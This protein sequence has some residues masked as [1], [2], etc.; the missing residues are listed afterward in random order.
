MD[1]VL[2][3]DYAAAQP[4]LE[5]FMQE[6]ST[7]VLN[8]VGSRKRPDPPRSL[9]AQPGSLEVLLTWNGPQ[10]ASDITGWRIYKNNENTLIDTITDP[11]THQYKAK[12]PANTN[13]GFYVS[14][15]NALG[16]ESI[17][18]FVVGAANTDQYVTTGTSGGTT[19]STAGVP[20]GYPSEPSGGRVGGNRSLRF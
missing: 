6:Q 1:S 12:V 18:V 13:T 7:L 15:V 2:P 11:S 3:T 14:S 9:I 19:G 17:K 5:R 20:P 16:V 10:K 8:T 4:I